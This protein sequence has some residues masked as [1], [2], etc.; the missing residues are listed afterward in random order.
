MLAASP[1]RQA[2]HCPAGVAS[3]EAFNMAVSHTLPS[4][5]FPLVVR[6][7]SGARY[8]GVPTREPGADWNFSCCGAPLSQ[9]RN[10]MFYWVLHS[11]WGALAL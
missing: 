7:T 6:M 8:A 4:Y 5:F 3:S 10:A 11:R 2:E 1:G 9:H